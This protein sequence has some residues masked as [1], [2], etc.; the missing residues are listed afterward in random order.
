MPL[1]IYSLCMHKQKRKGKVQVLWEIHTLLWIKML[2]HKL[3]QE[4][5]YNI[6][7]IPDWIVWLVW[8]IDF[9]FF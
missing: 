2:V 4:Y 7:D 5:T 9:S 3:I 8:K 1:I 6:Q